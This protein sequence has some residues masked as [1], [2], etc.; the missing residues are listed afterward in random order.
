MTKK[1]KTDGRNHYSRI[2]KTPAADGTK[3]DPDEGWRR[4]S[5]AYRAFRED[6][7]VPAAFREDEEARTLLIETDRKRAVF[8]IIR[9]AS[10][11]RAAMLQAE[12]VSACKAIAAAAGKKAE[13]AGRHGLTTDAIRRAGLPEVVGEEDYREDEDYWKTA[14]DEDEIAFLIPLQAAAE[15]LWE[16]AVSMMYEAAKEIREEVE[17][18]NDYGG[19][20]EAISRLEAWAVAVFFTE[21]AALNTGREGIEDLAAEAVEAGKAARFGKTKI[22][23]PKEVRSRLLEGLPVEVAAANAVKAAFPDRFPDGLLNIVLPGGP[24]ADR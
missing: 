24:E 16:E 2:R 8:S 15:T 9:A 18:A 17:A 1:R 12:R 4:A 20:K 3:I 23:F 14:A 6:K 5:Q 21:Q 19:R 10:A 11:E 13:I 22:R 7:E